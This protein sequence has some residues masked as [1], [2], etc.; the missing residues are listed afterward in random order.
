MTLTAVTLDDKYALECGR[1]FLTGTQALVRLPMMQRQRDAA[2]GLNTGCFI[3]GY[4]GSPLGGLDQQ[5]WQARR[6]LRE[7]PH[8]LP[9][10]RQRGPRGHRASGAASRSTCSATAELRWRLRHVVR[11]GP[12]RRPQRRR[13]SSTAMPP[14]RRPARR[15][16]AAG[17]RRSHLAKSSTLAHQMRIR[18]HGRHDPG[19][20]SG[21]RAGVSRSRPLRLGHVALFRLLGRLQGH[22]PRRWTARPASTSIRTACEIVHAGRFRDAA[23]RPQHPLAGPLAGPGRAPAPLQAA[24]R[25]WPSRAPTGST[26]SSSIA[27]N[28][29]SASSPPASPIWMCARR[30]TISAST[31]PRPPISA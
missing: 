7:Q 5:L 1:V 15:R 20:Q 13:A 11:Q 9:A 4:R 26:G 19:A 22:R 28:G 18:L 17:R 30:S 25:R 31:T 3:S 16:A 14:A 24:T 12:R 10:R 29:A 27:P 21:R 8:P 2:A 23:R 6:F